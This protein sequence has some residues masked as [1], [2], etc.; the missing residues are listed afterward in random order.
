MP[1]RS[2]ITNWP[3]RNAWAVDCSCGVEAGGDFAEEGSETAGASRDVASAS[4]IGEVGAARGGFVLV[5]PFFG[6]VRA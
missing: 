1:W 4:A 3:G 5:F 6:V 2:C